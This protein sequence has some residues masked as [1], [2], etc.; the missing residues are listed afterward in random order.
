MLAF[1]GG[2]VK[3]LFS[4]KIV[5]INCRGLSLFCFVLFVSEFDKHVG[6]KDELLGTKVTNLNTV[7]PHSDNTQAIF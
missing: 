1:A 6:A 7:T 5:L 3:C 4:M 2:R